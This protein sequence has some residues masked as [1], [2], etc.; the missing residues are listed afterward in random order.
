[1]EYSFL[2]LSESG[3]KMGIDHLACMSLSHV[4]TA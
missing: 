1:M 4:I 3:L 2:L